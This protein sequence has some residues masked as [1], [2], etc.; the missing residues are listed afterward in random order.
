VTVARAPLIV[1]CGAGWHFGTDWA[2]AAR[3][4]PSHSGVVLDGASSTG[5]TDTQDGHSIAVGGPSDVEV[6]L[7]ACAPVARLA[8]AH[9]GYADRYGLIHVRRIEL[10]LDG[11][12]IVGEE[13]LS[14]VTASEKRR[15]AQAKAEAQDG[16]AGLSFAVRFHLHP[17]IAASIDT[18]HNHVRL[19]LPC[20]DRW[21]F[22]AGDGVVMRLDPSIYL[23]NTR[24]DPVPSFQIVLHGRA[25][26]ATT[27]V[28]WR[29]AREDGWPAFRRSVPR[30]ADEE[31]QERGS[32]PREES[33]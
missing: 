23:E 28:S 16:A 9:N 13:L 27:I 29:L 18:A 5:F 3:R 30:D 7:D 4:T 22:R 25:L 10:A 17:D 33:E 26:H 32:R 21:A 14:A 20:G 19:D 12:Q 31:T 6:D 11:G 8:M 24:L 15:F 2:R 1:N